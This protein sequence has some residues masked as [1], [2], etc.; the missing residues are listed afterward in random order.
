MIPSSYQKLS[1]HFVP[2][3]PAFRA[4]RSWLRRHGYKSIAGCY[5][6]KAIAAFKAQYTPYNGSA[7]TR[8]AAALIPAVCT[9][10]MSAR[11]VLTALDS[12]GVFIDGDRIHYLLSRAVQKGHL[13]RTG[14]RGHYRYSQPTMRQA[15]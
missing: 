10:D 8:R 15:A 14:E 9:Y 7:V 4:A 2:K 3:S 1:T 13:E 5:Y 12:H 6:R 11:D